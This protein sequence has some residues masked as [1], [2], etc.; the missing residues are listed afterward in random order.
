[1]IHA[2]CQMCR[3]RQLIN[4][5]THDVTKYKKNNDNIFFTFPGSINKDKFHDTERL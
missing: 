1:M 4:Q 3:G 5:Y 2:I